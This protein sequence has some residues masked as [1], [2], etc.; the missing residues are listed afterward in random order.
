LDRPGLGWCLGIALLEKMEV[1]VAAEI[2]ERKEGERIR[3]QRK[4]REE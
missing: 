4:N 3:L 2:L 1:R